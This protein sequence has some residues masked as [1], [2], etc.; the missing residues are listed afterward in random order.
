[1]KLLFD[2]NLSPRLV[3]RLADI[4]PASQHIFLIGLERVN[5]LT[6]WEYARQHE[7][8]LVTKDSDFNEL[9]VLRKFP[10]KVIWIRR[11][12]CS[13]RQIEEILRGDLEDIQI[14]GQEPNFG[15]LTLY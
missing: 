10:P 4:Y 8:I 12:N 6:V 9:S 15:V 2:R 3:N 11:G 14:F 13:N 5:D 7:F 1:M